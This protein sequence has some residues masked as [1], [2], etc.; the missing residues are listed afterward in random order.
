MLITP[1][2]REALD[3]S[4]AESQPETT[5]VR[6]GM[7]SPSLSR[8]ARHAGSLMVALAALSGIVHS[9][10]SGG[11][12]VR[13]ATTLV[14]F[15]ATVW[16]WIATPIKDSYVALGA[17]AVLAVAGAID[18]G[19]VTAV[20]GQDLIWLLIGAF[21]IATAVTAT[22]LP[23]RYA[24]RLL[25]MART[26]RQLVHLVTAALIVATFAVPATSGRA[27]LALPVFGGLAAALSDRKQLTRCLA[28]LIPTVILL[29][30][31][32]SPIGAG[33]HLVTNHILGETVGESISF[34]QWLAAGLPL[35]VVWSHLAAEVILMLFTSA[36][37]RRT[38][39]SVPATAL[40]SD[41]S[42]ASGARLDGPQRRVV[43]LLAMVII[44]WC[45]GP[46]HHIAPAV[47][48][49]VGA[50]ITV[51]PR[52]G[53]T[54]MSDALK[55]VPWS[56]LTFMVA[57][58]A[59]GTAVTD[60]GAAE[61]LARAAFSPCNLLGSW[62]TSSFVIVLVVVSIGA[63]LVLQSRSARSAVLIPIVVTIAPMAGIAPVAAAFISTAAAGFCLTLTSSAKPVA[64]FA[65]TD[66]FPGY[67]SRDLLRLSAALA[68]LSAILLAL[69][70]F[71]VWPLL[72][73]SLYL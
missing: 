68:P 36:P 47:I 44:G 31:I 52:F 18:V 43:G 4:S 30:A 51:A 1:A 39:L 49:V 42:T 10:M 64:M 33:A 48:A 57:T 45:T 67:T 63:H 34:L 72:G 25:A 16:M 6:T 24:A 66:D 7:R 61:W 14:V 9:C 21:I 70:A 23:A 8:Y 28:M 22:G 5:G 58:L 20:V 38:R 26:P 15:L 55:A 27:V 50:L 54:S 19:D 37:D 17:V 2:T 3:L 35:A 60:S 71:D 11:L 29:S 32:A 13:G 40:A 69:F 59:L 65:A 12:S 53:T 46:I 41:E 73:L 62:A 56:L